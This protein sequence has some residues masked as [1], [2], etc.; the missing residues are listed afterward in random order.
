VLTGKVTSYRDERRYVH[1]NGHTIWIE[2]HGFALR[3]PTGRPTS[4]VAFVQDV[5]ERKQAEAELRAADRSK[6]EFLAMLAHELRNPLAPLLNVVQLLEGD[7]LS[8]RRIASLRGI[9]ERQIRNLSRM[10]DDLLDVARISQ[11][12]LQ[13]E[14]EV[15]EGGALVRRAAELFRPTIEAHDQRL[16]LA[17]PPEPVFLNADPVRLEQ[18]VDNLLTNASKFTPGK[19]N[20]WLSLVPPRQN[21]DMM[22][23]RV[24][25]DGSGIAPS[26]LHAIFEPFTQGDQSLDR[27]RGGLGIGLTLVK[28]VAELHGGT[29]EALSAGPRQGAEFV[30]RLPASGPPGR[31]RVL[32]KRDSKRTTPVERRVLVVDDNEDGAETLSMLLRNVGH[33]VAVVGDGETALETALEFRPDFVLLDI[34]LPGKDGYE[35]AREFR[36]RPETTDVTIV[37]VSGYGQDEDRRRAKAAGIDHYFTKPMDIEAL[38]ELLGG[39]GGGGFSPSVRRGLH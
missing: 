10:T 34:G 14:A 32:R 7:G 2:I 37:A 12:R 36:D 20:I 17:V 18:L 33:E 1:K 27:K 3:D 24:R 9:L 31:E 30:V 11:G 4:G 8:S 22:E 15:I 21:G 28:S 26:L 16:H 25:D 19:G 6:N 13:V 23:I 38:L 5:T 35:V 39:A 29:V